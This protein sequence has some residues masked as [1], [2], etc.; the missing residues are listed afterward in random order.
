[1]KK[2]TKSIKERMPLLDCKLNNMKKIFISLLAIFIIGSGCVSNQSIPQNVSIDQRVADMM[3][4]INHEQKINQLMMVPADYALAHPQDNF[5]GVFWPGWQLKNKTFSEIRS[6]NLKLKQATTTP[7]IAIDQEGGLVD[8]LKFISDITDH[9]DQ[10]IKDFVFKYFAKNPVNG[11]ADFILPSQEAIGEIYNSLSDDEKAEFLSD[12]QSLYARGLAKTLDEAGFTVNFAPVAD[13][14]PA[15]GFITQLDREDRTYGSNA[16]ATAQLLDAYAHG[17]IDYQNS[18]GTR[19]MFTFKHFPGIGGAK[20]DTHQP[21][22]LVN[23]TLN[24][25]LSSDISVY[26]KDLDVVPIIMLSQAVYPEIDPSQP[27]VAS[28]KIKNVLIDD[29]QYRGIII[30]DDIT[31]GRLSNLQDISKVCDMMLTVESSLVSQDKDINNRGVG[32][33]INVIAEMRSALN[34]LTDQEIDQKV[35]KILKNKL[36]FSIEN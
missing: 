28:Q 35:A 9:V 2:L 11:K 36:S 14:L 33:K 16:T 26:Q 17:F 5:G 22:V 32:Q 23:K 25:L 13:L 7:L 21:G 19:V 20:G 29:L 6:A 10:G 18:S 24:E 27:A 4:N 8:R 34:G 1:M 3:V 31:M 12:Y 30:S 15:D